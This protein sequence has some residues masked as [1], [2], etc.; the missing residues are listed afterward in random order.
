MAYGLCFMAALS[1]THL[2]ADGP[3]FADSDVEV[4]GWV[5]DRF[6]HCAIY[7]ASSPTVAFASSQGIWL[8]GALPHGKSARGNGPLDGKRVKFTGKFH[9]QPKNGAGHMGLFPAWLGVKTHT[10][11]DERAEPN[12]AGDSGLRHSVSQ[13]PDGRS[14]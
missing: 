3:R 9:W 10:V 2:I 6:E 1:V 11:V 14:A 12:S 4:V 13:G 7:D 5:V 8:S